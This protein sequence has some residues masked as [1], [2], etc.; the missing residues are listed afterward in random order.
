MAEELAYVLITPYTIGKSRTGGVIGRIIGRTGLDLVAARM[1]GPSRKL[2]E[3]YAELV[4]NDQE[5]AAEERDILAD[6]ILRALAPDEASG[7]P[8]RVLMLLF[9]G[10]DAIRK[11]REV[12]GS[13]RYSMDSAR[14]VREIYGDFI[15]GGGGEVLYIEPAVLIGNGPQS[16]AAGLRLWSRYSTPDGGIIM[17]GVDVPEDEGVERTLVIIKPD[18]FR[19]PSVRPG[20]IIDTFSG[21]GLRI[22]GAKVH[23]M[24]VA[25]AEEFYGPVRGVLR[26]KLRGR[27]A[28]LAGK[29]LR[30]ELGCEIP[31]ELQEKIGEMLAPVYGDHQFNEIVQFMTGY[32]PPDCAPAEKQK[33]GRE[34]CLALVYAGPD[35]VRK[36]REILG[37]TDPRKAQPGSVRREFGRDVMVNAAHASDSPDNAVREMRILRVDEDT[38]TPWVEKMEL[39]EGS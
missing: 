2:V 1:F 27:V 37:P 3:E 33:P 15:T 7:R 8:R 16:V 30:S 28:E 11:V 17:Q 31:V 35:A 6:Y 39:V 26:E 5:S 10:E 19:V 32:W 24:S 25:E 23:R 29:A 4:R 12:T 20:S 38:I 14:T 9:W 18:N 36:I 34:R 21:S 13:A 22:V